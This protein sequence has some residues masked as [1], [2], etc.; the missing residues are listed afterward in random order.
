[1]ARARLLPALA[2]IVPALAGAAS[3]LD[4][5]QSAAATVLAPAVAGIRDEIPMLPQSAQPKTHP[6]AV[7]LIAAWEVG[8]RTAYIRRWSG[9]YYP[10]GASGPTW[11]IGYDGGHQTARRIRADWTE[12]P[13]VGRLQET[14]GI[15]GTA[16]KAQ[17]SRWRG[18][19]TPYDAAFVVFEEI[20]LPAYRIQARRAFGPRF[21]D[22]PPRAAGALVSL[23][24]NRGGGMTGNAR[25]EMRTIRD[26]CLPAQDVACIAQ[27]LAAMCRLWAGTPNGDGL[28]SRRIAEGALAQRGEAP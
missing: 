17:I 12:H 24:Y 8:S 6:D 7:A 20:S 16:A 9:V 10:G 22:L 18:I 3:P 15:S 21:D 23:V 14:A 26:R 27:Q 1:M 4:Q 5:A 28:C 2:L 25:A 11:G 13:A 19:S